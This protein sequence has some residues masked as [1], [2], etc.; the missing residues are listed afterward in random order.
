MSDST[1][2]VYPELNSEQNEIPLINEIS[3]SQSFL[4]SHNM[5]WYY[6]QW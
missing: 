4:I 1:E 2:F 3:L 5:Y 6:S